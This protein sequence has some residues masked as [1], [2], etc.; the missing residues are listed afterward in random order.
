MPKIRRPPPSGILQH[1][2]QR[3]REG[4]IKEADILELKNWLET[5]PTVPK[6]KWFKRFNTG[7][8]AG[9]GDLPSTLLAPGMALDGDEVD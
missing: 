2:L 6:G 8:L 9:K 3:Y 5:D 4:R 7:T 1:L